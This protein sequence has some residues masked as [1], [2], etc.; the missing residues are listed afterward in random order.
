MIIIK[1]SLDSE[2]KRVAFDDTDASFASLCKAIKAL[3]P[4]LETRPFTIKYKD[5]EGDIISLF[6][7]IEFQECLRQTFQKSRSQLPVLRLWIDTVKTNEKTNT[8]GMYLFFRPRFSRHA[9]TREQKIRTEIS[10]RIAFF[11]K[12][13]LL[14]R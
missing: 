14:T 1:V 13:Y 9:S 4:V 5:D 10:T 7:D 12:R 8:V 3:F 2:I 11:M 6:S